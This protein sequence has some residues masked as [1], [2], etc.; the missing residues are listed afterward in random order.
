MFKG[1]VTAD[2]HLRKDR[3][4]CRIDENWINTQEDALNQVADI[5]IEHDCD[6]FLVG[7]I[8]HRAS[9]FEMVIYIQKLAQKLKKNGLSVYYLC[10]NHDMLYHSTLNLDK[11]AIGLLRNSE[12]CFFIKDYFDKLYFNSG[13]KIL[14]SASNFDEQ[15]YENAEI[16]FKHVLTIPEDD[17]PDFV[18]CETPEILLKKFPKA[19]LIF[20]GDY[21]KN[22]H[23]EKNGRHVI[24]SGCLLRQASDFKDY[25]SGV[26]FCD[27]GKN[28]VEFIPIIENVREL[29]DDSYITKENEREKRIDDFVDKL[30]NTQSVSFDFMDNVE[31]AIL[32]NDFSE[33]LKDVIHE[34][35]EV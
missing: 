27:M 7:D 18:D 24:N 31:K 34:L 32:V 21:H 12:N 2:W 4:R 25:V 20:T 9:E 33:D 10:G 29:I 8:F 26:Y 15:D 23:Y 13:E 3:P 16:V 28:I 6:L 1:I 22:F 14:F 17:K 35:L 5:C 30:K 19:Q 11:S